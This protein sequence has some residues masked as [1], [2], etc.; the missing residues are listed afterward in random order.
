[1]G[2]GQGQL[3]PLDDLVTVLS[4]TTGLMV[5]DLSLNTGKKQLS[6]KTCSGSETVPSPFFLDKVVQF[7]H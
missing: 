4:G 5:P 6:G 1:M 2:T 3:L 7:L